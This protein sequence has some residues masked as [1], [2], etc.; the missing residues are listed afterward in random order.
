MPATATK[1]PADQAPPEK[2]T[3]VVKG[4]AMCELRADQVKPWR[5]GPV[6]RVYP[7]GAHVVFSGPGSHSVRARD[8]GRWF[9]LVQGL[10]VLY[11]TSYGKVTVHVYDEVDDTTA[12]IWKV[13]DA[14]GW[15][16][17]SAIDLGEL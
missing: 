6:A 13:E 14:L 17:L 7:D 3:P 12:E 15:G 9:E 8:G 5:G 1:P 11:P 4:G 2:P 16:G 10:T